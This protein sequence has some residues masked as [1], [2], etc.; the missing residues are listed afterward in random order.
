MRIEEAEGRRKDERK[1]PSRFIR[2]AF[3]VCL[4]V[5]KKMERHSLC[6]VTVCAFFFPGFQVERRTGARQNG[7]L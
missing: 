1:S 6:V 3:V 4:C 7:E 5:C 2:V